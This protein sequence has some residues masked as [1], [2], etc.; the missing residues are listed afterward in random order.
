[1]VDTLSL[2]VGQH[3]VVGIGDL[4]AD[5]QRHLPGCALGP[6]QHAAGEAVF[7]HDPIGVDLAFARQLGDLAAM[8]DGLGVATWPAS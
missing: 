2:V 4:D 3:L 5:G 6:E 1:M 8:H 7:D